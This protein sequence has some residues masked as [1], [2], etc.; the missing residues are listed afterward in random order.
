V[1]PTGADLITLPLLVA[2]AIALGVAYFHRIRTE[3]PPVGVYTLTDIAIM[4]VAVIAMPIAYLHLPA[5]VVATVLGL[6]TVVVLQFALAP[7]LT[8]RFPPRLPLLLSIGAAAIDVALNAATPGSALRVAAPLWNNLLLLVLIIGIGN[9]YA[10][11]GMKARDVAIFTAILAGY[12]LVATLLLPTMSDLLR[13]V[14]ELPF[15]PVFATG[16]GPHPVTIGLGDVLLLVLWTLVAVKGYG[17]AAGWLASSTAVTLTATLAA[18]IGTGLISGAFPVMLI[19]GPV[20]TAEYLLLRHRHGPERT[21]AAYYQTR[22]MR[23]D[24]TSLGR[25]LE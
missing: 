7:V 17:T 12:D 13:K 20:V 21:T 10:Q 9:L 14:A 5:A 16:P 4:T 8:G 23:A 18:A 15:A 2:A 22:P 11:S 6:M 3:R 24:V 25:E 19:A 1:K